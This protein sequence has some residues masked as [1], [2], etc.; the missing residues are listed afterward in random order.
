MLRWAN[1]GIFHRQVGSV[2][3]KGAIALAWSPKGGL[4]QTY[5][6][7]DREKGNAHKNLKVCRLP[8][9]V[10]RL[11]W[12]QMNVHERHRTA[13]PGR[14]DACCGGLMLNSTPLGKC[15]GEGMAA[16]NQRLNT[17]LAILGS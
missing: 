13:G 11:A 6:R 5:E 16:S 3:V 9:V 7:V 14:P 1:S 4:M 15:Y 12:E 8:S 10:C 2:D 17:R